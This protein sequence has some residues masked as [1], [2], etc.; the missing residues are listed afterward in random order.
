[1]PID[2]YATLGIDPLA[3][4]ETVRQAWVSAARTHHPDGLGEVTEDERRSAERRMHDIN[5]AWRILGSKELRS[6]YDKE[7]ELRKDQ[8]AAVE[9]IWDEDWFDADAS[10]PPGFEVGNPL[11]ATVLRV[12]PWLV[13]GAIGIGI[14]VFSAFA[15][16]SRSERWD[17]PISGTN[18]DECVVIKEDGTVKK[19]S[20]GLCGEPFSRRVV[21]EFE[22][23]AD[24]QCPGDTEKTEHRKAY[25]YYCLELEGSVVDD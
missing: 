2:H 14:F 6:A 19:P 16:N 25:S 20:A 18:E 5:E 7:R 4:H 12:L 15:T 23:D 11:V 8:S 1:M 13:V 22:M 10:D 24:E 9:D 21:T 3:E 17:L